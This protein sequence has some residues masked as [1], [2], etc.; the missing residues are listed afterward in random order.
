[1]KIL[2]GI[3]FIT[4]SS[5]VFLGIQKNAVMTQI[6]LFKQSYSKKDYKTSKNI[7]EKNEKK[8]LYKKFHFIEN[9]STFLED[10]LIKTEHQFL[11]GHCNYEDAILIIKETKNYKEV[12]I[13]IIKKAEDKINNKYEAQNTYLEAKKFLD[14]KNFENALK[15]VEYSLKLYSD[16]VEAKE[17]KKIIIEQYRMYIFQEVNNLV[18]KEKFN[19][20]LTLLEKNKTIFL[21]KDFLNK[22]DEV[23]KARKNFEDKQEK[24]KKLAEE[25]E[26]RKKLAEE[27]LKK[28]KNNIMTLKNNSSNSNTAVCING[29]TLKSATN[30]LIYVDT[31]NQKTNVFSNTNGQWNL[32]KSISCSTGKS[33]SE[34]PSGT[35]KVNYRG[36]WFYSNKYSEGA[37]Y[38][39][40]FYGNYLFHSLPMD[41]NKKIV[42][43]TLGK[44]ASHGC[45]RLPVEDA[46]WIYNNIPNGTTVY[47]K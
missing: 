30:F 1:M 4:A 2:I 42:D 41:I 10:N 40:S 16:N 44:P 18:N 26:R 5:V 17:L 32:S 43:Y 9:I 31:N 21:E 23:N 34:T 6:N 37:K 24:E 36:T 35:Y 25:R 12:D 7:Y 14:N 28:T 33:G 20:A 27:K 45:V 13:D 47:I 46:K 19:D 22:K 29:K 39:V 15:K 11:D 3:L 8:Y 38:W